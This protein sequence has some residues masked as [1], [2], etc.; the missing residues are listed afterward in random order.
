MYSVGHFKQVDRNGSAEIFLDG[1]E[2]YIKW[3]QIQ[4]FISVSMI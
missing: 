4:V 1:S 3:D 2:W